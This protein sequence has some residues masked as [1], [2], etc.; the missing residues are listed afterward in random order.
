MTSTISTSVSRPSAK[1]RIEA[2]RKRVQS[3]IPQVF[4]GRARLM[5][6]SYKETE[7]EPIIIRRA[8]AL[9]HILSNMSI[10]IGEDELIVG[11]YIEAVGRRGCP[12][13]IE[14]SCDWL[15]DEMDQL[16][17]REVDKAFISD[18]DKETLRGLIPFWRGRTVKE[19]AFFLMPE[20][21]RA[22]YFEYIDVCKDEALR[23]SQSIAHIVVDYEKVIT[24]GLEAVTRE[25]N[26]QLQEMDLADPDQLAKAHFYRAV[27][28]SHKAVTEFATRYANLA[29]K[30]AR[31]EQN[32]L[33]KAELTEIA[34]ICECV[35]AKPARTFH[36]ALQ[37][38]WFVHVALHVEANGVSIS[39]GRMDQ[40]LFHYY[41]RDIEEGRI[42]RE[43]AK[44][45]LQCFFIKLNSLALLL[46][47]EVS[48]YYA[49]WGMLQNITLGGVG[50][51]GR[52]VTNELSYVMLEA[53]G[54]LGLAQ[55]ETVVRVHRGMPR[56]FLIKSSEVAK[57]CRGKLKFIGDNACIGKLLNRGYT[58]ED[59]RDY[60]VVGCFEAKVPGK[61]SLAPAG[62]L[63]LLLC[64]ELVLNDGVSVL[65]N[66][67]L[68]P[69]TGNPTEFKSIQ[70][71]LKAYRTQIAHFMNTL[72]AI[73]VQSLK[74]MRNLH[75]LP[76]SL[77]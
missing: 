74:L 49:G 75:P 10:G 42:D 76:F 25:A 47:K 23:G 9:N 5:T 3:G 24:Q 58:L 18:E 62:H 73:A 7:G 39:P 55:P 35:P 17:E 6:E 71:V 70:D 68:G 37:S 36:E 15:E 21:L 54:D 27:S 51:D 69:R 11:N 67:Q 13:I 52:D 19:K 59:A 2:L 22:K 40:Y 53:D 31:K 44:E 64:L 14:Y 66:K 57:K 4:V 30:L 32:S 46:P 60:V 50:R 1:T 77:H 16:A 28:I 38:L 8:K 29:R 45:L 12:I 26:E 56:N 43:K 34:G 41:R 33:R 63:N 65:L 48:K 20:E 61:S 72:P